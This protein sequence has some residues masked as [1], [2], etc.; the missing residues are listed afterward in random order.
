MTPSTK[1]LDAC[2]PLQQTTYPILSAIHPAELHRL[3]VTHSLAYRGSLDLDYI[4]YDLLN[5]SS[6]AHQER[7]RSRCLFVPA[8]QN[9]LNNFAGLGIHASE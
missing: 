7:L 3:G 4:L 9:P 1:S 2:V 5:G 8:A 6:D